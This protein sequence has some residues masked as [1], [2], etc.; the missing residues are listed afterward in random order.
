M[1]NDIRSFSQHIFSMFI[2]VLITSVLLFVIIMINF[3]STSG[4][5]SDMAGV[6]F[7]YGCPF[8]CLFFF[9]P[10]TLGIAGVSEIG[11]VYLGDKFKWWITTPIMFLI[12]LLI[13]YSI[14]FLFGYK[15]SIFEQSPSTI[16]QLV[17]PLSIGI[18][19]FGFLY[20]AIL[21]YSE[22][23]FVSGNANQED[24]N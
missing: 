2:S 14:L 11:R 6:A 3:A 4:P 20:W 15:S 19:L 9:L 16:H 8:L 5:I 10:V 24:N 12:F 13:S 18:S 23:V 17:F 1:V 7:F 22:T 21:L